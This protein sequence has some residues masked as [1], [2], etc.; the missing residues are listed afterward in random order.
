[1]IT[2]PIPNGRFE[3]LHAD[4]IQLPKSEEGYCYVLTMV[5]SFTHYLETAKLKDK[6]ANSVAQA[7]VRKIFCRYGA[8]K[9]LI[10]D[11]GAEFTAQLFK[12]VCAILGIKNRYTSPYHPQSNSYCEATHFTIKKSL[13]K[14]VREDGHST[15]PQKLKFV[16]FAINTSDCTQSTGFSPYEMVFGRR[17][18]YPAEI[19]ITSKPSKKSTVAD[20]VTELQERLDEISKIVHENLTKGAEMRRAKY[21]HREWPGYQK[22]DRV[23]LYNPA[24]RA[25]ESDKLKCKWVGP[26]LIHSKVYDLNYKLQ[27]LEGKIIP[28]I[29]HAERLRLVL[30]GEDEPND[31][32]V[33]GNPTDN[34]EL[35]NN[36]TMELIPQHQVTPQVKVGVPKVRTKDNIRKRQ[37]DLSQST[38]NA[39]KQNS[40]NDSS[41]IYTFKKIMR[42]QYRNKKLYLR[43]LWSDDSMTWEPATNLV[44]QEIVQKYL[45]SINK[46]KPKRKL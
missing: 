5:D 43:I 34:E 11:N 25:G 23:Y 26:F 1:M 45:K 3:T 39:G 28:K 24:K 2:L 17:C 37:A 21:K 35:A 46:R 19:G 41:R 15:W 42:H 14:Y 7:L 13:A 22:N 38:Q 40:Q 36:L 10:T 6:S 9:Y 31:D 30:Y 29:V 8:M 12:D 27:T 32:P 20:Y 16:Q 33:I 4:L 44:S 18:I